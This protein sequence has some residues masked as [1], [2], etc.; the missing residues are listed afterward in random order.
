MKKYKDANTNSVW[1][2]LYNYY[3]G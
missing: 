3:S 2:Q 1:W